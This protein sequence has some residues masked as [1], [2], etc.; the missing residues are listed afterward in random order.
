M[1]KQFDI[2]ATQTFEH[3]GPNQTGAPG[4]KPFKQKLRPLLMVGFPV[5]FAAVGYAHYLAGVPFVSTDN[6]YARVA[7]A[8]INARISGQVVEIA[9][10]DNQPVRLTVHTR[11]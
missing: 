10:E 2:S 6:A 4:K 9:V 1:T 11:S 7:K 5:L 3:P 8:S